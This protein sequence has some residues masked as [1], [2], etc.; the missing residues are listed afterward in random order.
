MT[1]YICGPIWD[2]RLFDIN[3]KGKVGLMITGGVDSWVMYNLLK[4]LSTNITLFNIHRKDGF[5]NPHRVRSLT[6]KDVVEIDDNGEP[7]GRVA[8][9]VDNILANYEIDQLYLALNRDP[10]IEHFPQFAMEGRPFR[11]WRINHQKIITPFLHLYKYHIIDV[12][13]CLNIN[14]KDTL[15]CIA[16][17]SNPCGQCWQCLE[18]HWGYDQLNQP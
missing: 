13:N 12:A 14:L 17:N 5:D 8:A 1:K 6:G 16:N 3:P 10:P 15:S 11:P 7:N 2:R 18:R 4:P 9:G